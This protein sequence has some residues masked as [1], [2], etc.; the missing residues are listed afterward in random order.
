M[1]FSGKEYWLYKEIEDEFRQSVDPK[2]LS[3]Y[4][5][6][7][8]T[9][10]E[11]VKKKITIHYCTVSLKLNFDIKRN[12]RR[13]FLWFYFSSNPGTSQQ[14]FYCYLHVEQRRTALLK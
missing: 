12:I 13:L 9:A 2:I 1:D 5:K 6:P 8:L 14:I 3:S 7:C 4:L 10:E 11:M